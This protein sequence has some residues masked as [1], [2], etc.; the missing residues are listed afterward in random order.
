[1]RITI[2]GSSGYPRGLQERSSCI[3]LPEYGV[4]LDAGSGLVEL[5]QQPSYRNTEKFYLLL[6]HFHVDHLIGLFYV[7]PFIIPDGKKL[8]VMGDERL[9]ELGRLFKEPFFSSMEGSPTPV[10]AELLCER[11]V[12]NNAEISVARFPH[13]IAWTNGF[14]LTD[15]QKTLV[16]ITDTTADSAQAKFAENADLLIH[17]CNYPNRLAEKARTEGHSYTDVVTDFA[18]KAGVK[19]LIISHTE[20]H[21]RDEIIQEVRRKFIHADLAS[22]DLEIVI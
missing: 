9:P 21:F 18:T 19:Q 3:F 13:D 14:R 2:L 22:D 15:G 8:V 11:F 12:L 5:P 4:I 10:Q 1:M 16:Y 6:T 7:L 17:E 20:Y